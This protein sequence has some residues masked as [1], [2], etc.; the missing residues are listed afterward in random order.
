M[1][2]TEQQWTALAHYLQEAVARVAPEWADRGAHDPGITVLEVLN[3]AL[4]DLQFRRPTEDDRAR[5]LAQAVADHAS[6]LASRYGSNP[7]RPDPYRDFKFRVKWDGRYVAG[8]S[9]VSA[10]KR[11]TEVI[12]FREGGDPTTPRRLPGPTRYE[13]I[14]L[15]RGITSDR[16]FEAWANAVR[17]GS[18]G[19]APVV[20]RD[21]FIELFDLTGQLASSYKVSGC[22]VS[23]YQALPDLDAERQTVLI[24]TLRLECEGWERLDVV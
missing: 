22:W 4:T 24:E 10:L 21:V 14:T 17:G 11:T 18:S 6:A 9:K 16:E 13:P 15:E 1:A 23:H 8:V 2:L 5:S 20:P 19:S 3:Y 7:H 12:E